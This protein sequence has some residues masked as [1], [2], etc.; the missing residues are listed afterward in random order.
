MRLFVYFIEKM[1]K[2]ILR[3]KRREKKRKHLHE[4]DVRYCSDVVSLAKNLVGHCQGERNDGRKIIIASL[5][6]RIVVMP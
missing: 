2:K 4:F 3:E 6:S 5:Y 1:V